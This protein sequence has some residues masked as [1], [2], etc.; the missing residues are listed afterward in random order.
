MH[1]EVVRSSVGEGRSGTHCCEINNG[2]ILLHFYTAVVCET[3]NVVYGM[4]HFH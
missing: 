2:G 1:A 3:V 4:Q